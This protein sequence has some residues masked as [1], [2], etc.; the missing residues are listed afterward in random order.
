M[1]NEGVNQQFTAAL[2]GAQ[3]GDQREFVIAYPEDYNSQTYA[4]RR[5]QYRASVVNVQFKELP[6]L[7]DQFAQV[8]NDKYQTMED[9]RKETRES[10]EGRVSQSADAELRKAAAKALVESHSFEVPHGVLERRLNL[11]MERFAHEMSYYGSPDFLNNMDFSKLREMMRES[12]ESEVRAD[13]ILDRIAEAEQVEVSEE[14]IDQEITSLAAM[15]KRSPAE[16]KARF[17]EEGTIDS[18][19]GQIK[20][21]KALDLVV[22]SATLEVEE[23]EGGV[24]EE[25]LSAADEAEEEAADAEVVDE[26]DQ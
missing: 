4:G 20:T 19:A 10:I 15:V 22:A 12:A 2:A 9:L 16:L 5:V 7:N 25:E 11:K 23:I 21:R 26:N 6:E 17:T 14:E 18:I 1:S 8:V 24:P 3:A 13:F